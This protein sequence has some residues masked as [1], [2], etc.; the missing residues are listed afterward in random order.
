MEHKCALKVRLHE[1]RDRTDE[2][3]MEMSNRV[4]VRVVSFCVQRSRGVLGARP[5]RSAEPACLLF[6]IRRLGMVYKRRCHK[7]TIV[8]RELRICVEK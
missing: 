8:S 1:N 7:S 2:T 3:E 6:F 4:L 5:L